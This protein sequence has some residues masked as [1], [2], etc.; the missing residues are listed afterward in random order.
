MFSLFLLKIAS[1]ILKHISNTN[2]VCSLQSS[3]GDVSS[4][5]TDF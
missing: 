1:S 4:V 2:D 3:G 5:V